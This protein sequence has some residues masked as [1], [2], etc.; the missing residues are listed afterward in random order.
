MISGGTEVNSFT[1]AHIIL[2]AKFGDRRVMFL[3]ARVWFE[4]FFIINPPRPNPRQRKFT[5]IFIFILLYGQKVLWR[6]LRF[7]FYFN[8]VFWNVRGAELSKVRFVY[9]V[10][11][12]FL[13]TDY[14]FLQIYCNMIVVVTANVDF[15]N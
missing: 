6:P 15:F 1:K 10:A 8:T 5:E 11:V 7:G 13:C 9:A 3:L 12:S 14:N 2:E 4:G